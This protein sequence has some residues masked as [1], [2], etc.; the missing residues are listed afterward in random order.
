MTFTLYRLPDGTVVPVDSTA[1]K[2]AP[3]IGFT[4]AGGQ[5]VDATIVSTRLVWIM[6]ELPDR[7]ETRDI[8][9]VFDRSLTRRKAKRRTHTNG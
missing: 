7:G 2:N 8:M 5:I 6:T 9:R 1:A 4:L 3:V